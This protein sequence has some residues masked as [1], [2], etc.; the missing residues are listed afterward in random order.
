MQERGSGPAPL[1]FGAPPWGRVSRGLD[2]VITPP[3]DSLHPARPPHHPTLCLPH[4]PNT[5]PLMGCPCLCPPLG[6]PRAAHLQNRPGKTHV[7]LEGREGALPPRLFCRPGLCSQG[8]GNGHLLSRSGASG[9]SLGSLLFLPKRR[10]NYSSASASWP[11]SA[12]WQRGLGRG[13]RLATDWLHRQAGSSSHQGSRRLGSRSP[14]HL[15]SPAPA[16]PGHRKGTAS[17]TRPGLC[18]TVPTGGRHR[19]QLAPP[20]TDPGG[21]QVRATQGHR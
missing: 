20:L 17:E 6:F 16:P 19:A 1:F 2:S 21:S 3:S 15:S 12:T 7:G 13:H 10:G 9:L 8:L 11:G 5:L 4:P 18:C 14:V